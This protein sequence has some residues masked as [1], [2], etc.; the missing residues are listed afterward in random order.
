MTVVMGPQRHKIMHITHFLVKNN[1]SLTSMS[2]FKFIIICPTD[3]LSYLY[4]SFNSSLFLIVQ[5]INERIAYGG[6]V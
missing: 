5:D 2:T 1:G 3:K 6:Q 4:V